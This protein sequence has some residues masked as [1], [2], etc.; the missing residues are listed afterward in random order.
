MFISLVISAIFAIL[1]GFAGAIFIFS[2]V[3]ICI[4]KAASAEDDEFGE[5]EHAQI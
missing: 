4:A 2:V 3:A 1:F 5:D